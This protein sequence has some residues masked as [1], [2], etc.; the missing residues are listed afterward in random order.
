MGLCN[1][2]ASMDMCGVC[3]GGLTNHK[4]NSDMDCLGVCFGNYTE[5]C[6]LNLKMNLTEIDAI[7]D[8]TK[9]ETET[10]V[11]FEITNE[12]MSL[13]FYFLFPHFKEIIRF[14]LFMFFSSIAPFYGSI[15]SHPTISNTSPPEVFLSLTKTNQLG[16]VIHVPQDMMPGF[17]KLIVSV[18]VSVY[19]LFYNSQIYQ[20]SRDF[21]DLNVR[22]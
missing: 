11:Q 7:I 9:S 17:A 2:A 18:R 4:A 15:H 10:T 12:C 21:I 13:G 20:H 8:L 14:L 22:F 3:S 6:L 19:G 5:N 1:G 16:Q